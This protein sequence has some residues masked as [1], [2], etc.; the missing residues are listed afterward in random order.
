MKPTH[1]KTKII[2]TYGPACNTK[3]SLYEIIKAGVDVVRFN[4]SHGDHAFH[5]AGFDLVKEIN[6]DYNLNVAILADLQGP[7]IRVG[8]VE[9]G[10]VTL[11]EDSIVTLHHTKGISNEKQIYI[12][13]EKL[14]EDL[15]K[16]EIILMDDGKLQLQ[17][18][19]NDRSNAIS[20][21]VLVGGI[22]SSKKGVNF[23]NTKTSVPSLTEKDIADLEFACFH[24]ANWIALSFVRDAADVQDLRRRID[25]N[26]NFIKIIS[27]IEKPEAVQHIDKIIEVSDAIMVARGDLAV[28]VAIERMPLIQKEIVKKC[29]RKSKP[30]VVATQMMESMIQNPMP[31]RAEITDVANALIDGADAVMLSAETSVGKYPVKV[32]ET[33]EKIIRSIER[34]NLIYDNDHPA[35]KS[36]NTYVSDRICYSAVRIAQDIKAK[37]ILGV[38]VSGYTGFIVSSYRPRAG[39]FLFTSNKQMLCTLNICWGVKAFYYDEFK[40]TDAT[41]SDLIEILKREKFINT[42]DY[43][44]NCASM[45]LKAKGRTNM[46][47]VT[48]V[49]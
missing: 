38:T 6:R 21:K 49:F 26:K 2:A 23:P 40:D 31:T 43:V 27:K 32:I 41:I 22:L 16:G 28:E 20:A 17:I 33:V 15:N 34:S 7:K 5:K 14:H 46:V 19:S 35:D 47:K 1:N 25:A 10:A 8:E 29:I 24:D 37:A 30:V 42:G 18:L 45:P 48:E 4:F 9:N 39:I 12:S 11:V 36:S 13:Y 3:E 44:V